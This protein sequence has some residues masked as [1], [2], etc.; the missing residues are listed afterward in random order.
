[1]CLALFTHL[2]EHEIE[3]TT[4]EPIRVKPYSVPFAKRKAID[5]E[6]DK[7]LKAGIIEECTSEYNSPVVL[8]KKK[9]GS[10][11]FCI[12]F[13]R[14]NTITKFDTEPMQNYE[15]IMAQVGGD[16]IFSKIDFSKGYWQIPMSPESKRYTAFT[17]SK[18]TFQFTRNPFG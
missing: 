7:M 10:N 18:G 17:T 1:M 11:R 2:G 3:L 4:K 6:V 9:D 5:E 13:R 16:K 15:D 8:V 12:D 14:L